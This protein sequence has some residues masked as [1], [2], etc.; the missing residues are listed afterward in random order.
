LISSENL[1]WRDFQ[2][3]EI[4]QMGL[5]VMHRQP[6]GVELDDV[7]IHPVNL[8]PALLHQLGLETVVLVAGD[9]NWPLAIVTLRHFGRFAIGL[10]PSSGPV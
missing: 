7:V 3:T 8:S 1:V 4:E 9:S 6:G 5:Y 10:P 2:A